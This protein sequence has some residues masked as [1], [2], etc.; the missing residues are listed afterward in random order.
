VN[1]SRTSNGEASFSL[2]SQ[3]WRENLRAGWVRFFF[4]PA[5]AI[6]LHVVRLLGGLLLLGWLLSSIGQVADLYGLQGWFD[7][8][9]YTEA[10]RFPGGPPKPITWSALYLAGD[11]PHALLGLYVASL[12]VLALFALGIGTRLTGLLSWVIVASFTANPAVDTEADALLLLLSFYL[13]LGY[14]LLDGGSSGRLLDWLRGR[15]LV[16]PVDRLW[17]RWRGRAVLPEKPSAA[18]NFTLRLLQV[19]LAI[20]IAVSGLHKLQFGDWWAG[21]AFWYLLYP[22]GETTVAQVQATAGDA[23]GSLAMLAAAAYATLAWQVTFPLFAWRPRWRLVLLG[24]AVVG[25]LGTAFLYRLPFFGPAV[26]AACLSYVSGAEWRWLA[27]WVVRLW[28]AGQSKEVPLP[29]EVPAG[30]GKER[31]TG[32]ITA[33]RR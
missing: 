29:E 5:D 20:V 3:G 33:E 4:T 14:L 7:R 19:H 26:L 28:K 27:G 32:L 16:W 23:R 13:M 8:Q 1:T 18:A 30:R 17:A 22:A 9:A 15:A 12:A 11:S 2:A 21:L 25:W 6:P 24:G 10:S 31:S